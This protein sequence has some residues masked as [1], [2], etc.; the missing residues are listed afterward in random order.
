ML[1]RYLMQHE[2]FKYSAW[3]SLQLAILPF[4]R[5]PSNVP[6]TMMLSKQKLSIACFCAARASCW[7]SMI[8]DC[9]LRTSCIRS[10]LA[11]T[12]RTI[13]SWFVV[14]RS[15]YVFS[16]LYDAL[17]PR[18]VAVLLSLRILTFSCNESMSLMCFNANRAPS[19][20]PALGRLAVV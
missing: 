5:C 1:S 7:R 19:P 13:S 9:F 3:S 17:A 11:L 14:S 12:H 10:L 20:A 6:S 2:S 8:S 16:A 15:T 4:H 18:S